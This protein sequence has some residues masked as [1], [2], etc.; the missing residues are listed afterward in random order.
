MDDDKIL[1]LYFD[2]DESAIDESIEKYG[3]LC[4]S[5][6]YGILKNREDAEECVND[7]FMKVWQTVPPKKPENLSAFCA[8]ISRNLAIDKYR[9]DTSKKRSGS[10]YDIAIEELGECIGASEVEELFDEAV[11]TNAINSFLG[12]LSA[13]KCRVFMRRYFFFDNIKDI[14]ERY[15]LSTSSVKMILKRTREGLK[16]FLEKEGIEI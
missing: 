4:S 16:E 8:K 6:A 13:K 9:K 2:R 5:I 1:K 14:S 10:Q 11:V 7:T 12:T 3:A 15:G